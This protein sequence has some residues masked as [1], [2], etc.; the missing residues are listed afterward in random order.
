MNIYFQKH[1]QSPACIWKS[2]F[3]FLHFISLNFTGAS[4]SLKNGDEETALDIA[5]KEEQ[6]AVVA[7]FTSGTALRLLYSFLHLFFI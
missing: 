6:D 7:L 4:R 3:Y 1:S 5:Q 2:P